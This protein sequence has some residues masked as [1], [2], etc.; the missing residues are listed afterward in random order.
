MKELLNKS[1][2]LLSAI[3]CGCMSMQAQQVCTIKGSIE[4]DS[5]RYTPKRFKIVYLTTK[6]END[7]PVTL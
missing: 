5:L 4:N 7:R 1:V 6:D 3:F 2:W